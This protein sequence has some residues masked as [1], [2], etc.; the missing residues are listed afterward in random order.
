MAF[1]FGLPVGKVIGKREG[2][3]YTP[4]IVESSVECLGSKDNNVQV[5]PYHNLDEIGCSAGPSWIAKPPHG[6]QDSLILKCL[7]VAMSRQVH[8]HISIMNLTAAK[9]IETAI[10]DI[11]GMAG[12]TGR[13]LSMASSVS[14]NL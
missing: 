2:V 4:G 6:A 14:G 11:G 12:Y 10:Q 9:R 8:A 13:S 7:P 3:K 5:R 1:P